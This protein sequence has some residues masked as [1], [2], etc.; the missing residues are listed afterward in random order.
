MVR[1]QEAIHGSLRVVLR[2]SERR[3]ET[4]F[5]G[6]SDRQ[7]IVEA[8]KRNHRLLRAEFHKRKG[9]IRDMYR[10]KMRILKGVRGKITRVEAEL[11]EAKEQL[12]EAQ[13]ARSFTPLRREALCPSSLHPKP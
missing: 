7:L 13:C 1:I 6:M 3:P 2:G 11:I 10:Q 12:S 9:D 8:K 5:G 4:G